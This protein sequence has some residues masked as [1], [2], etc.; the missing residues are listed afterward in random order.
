M[1]ASHHRHP[2]GA[3]LMAYAAGTLGEALSAVVAAHLGT[4]PACRREERLL[5]SLGGGLLDHLD[6]EAPAPP[7]SRPAPF[8]APA[9]GRAAVDSRDP[10]PAIIQQRYGLKLAEVP[11]KTMGPGLFFH[12]LPLS[13]GTP[14]ELRLLKISGGRSIPEHAHAGGEL[15][16]V[17]EGGFSDVT[18]RYGPGDVQDIDDDV[19][20][21]PV[22]DPEGCI[23]LVAAEAPAE[24][25]GLIGRLVQAFTRR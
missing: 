2:D 13:E 6:G 25:K 18:G 16:L 12:W 8:D 19:A 9:S 23:C 4:C 17:I 21:T 5:A 15:T 11:W 3:T 22:A 20:H 1:T 10:M 7:P 24:F 14:G